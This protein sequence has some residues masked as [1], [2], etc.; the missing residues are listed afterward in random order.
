MT[1]LVAPVDTAVRALL[2]EDDADHAALVCRSLRQH[3]AAIE[4]DVVA[5]G[6]EALAALA[7]GTYALV[8][9]DYHLPEMTGLEVLR[10]VRASGRDV[11]VVILT[12]DGDDRAVTDAMQAGAIDYVI[13]TPGYFAGLGTVVSKALKQHALAREHAR[14]YAEAQSQARELGI[15]YELGTALT[16]T[17]SLADVLD[18]VAA[19]ALTL[20]DGARCIVFEVDAGENELAARA[21]RHGVVRPVSGMRLSALRVVPTIYAAETLERLL[22]GTTELLRV[23]AAREGARAVLAVPIVSKGTALGAIAVFWQQPRDDDPRELR[24][25]TALAQPAAVAIENARLYEE[26]QRTMAQLTAMQEHLVRGETLRALGELAGGVAHHLNNL[27]AVVSARTQ[28]LLMRPHDAA[29]ERPLE[30]IQ[31]AATDGAEVVRRIQEFARSRPN[32]KLEPLDFN[33]VVADVVELTRPRWHDAA[34]AQGIAIELRVETVNVPLIIGEGAALRE[35]VTNLIIN[36]VDALPVG[37]TITLR[38]SVETGTV[39]LTVIDDGVGMSEDVLR[40]AQEPFFTTKGVKSMG[41]GLSVNYGIVRQHQGT[42][43]IASGEGCGTTVTVRLPGITAGNTPE[44]P[45]APTPSS[46][47]RVWIVDDEPEVLDVV[48]EVLVE[49]GHDV[50]AFDDPRDAA[51]RLTHEAP[52]VLITDLGMPELRGWDLAR[53]A[54]E[55]WPALPVVVMTA[56]GSVEV[57]VEA[58][59][60]GAR[61]F[62]QKPWENTRLLTILRTQIELARALRRQQRLEAENRSLK[63][64]ARP[65]LIAEAPSMRPV[66]ELIARVGPSEANIL[67][68]GENGT[69]KGTVA[70]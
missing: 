4:V 1:R 28:L 9:L 48:R 26:M 65:L 29:I 3:D 46:P 34:R 45:A 35:V 16:S 70:Q 22:P 2:V 33:A 59:R 19:G 56:W 37:G 8:L 55:C 14:L 31:Q 12:A 61:D 7:A 25:L 51:T 11:A 43:D 18:A 13:K 24:L 50:I 64:D 41:L 30:I 6:R 63:P 47:R 49:A 36:A 66:L 69:G 42:I 10:R 15:L 17:H 21:T 5:N 39:V 57:A 67:V 68:T 32:Q 38:T 60:R 54:K 20:I 52:D 58:M 62:V 27:L 44:P 23:A 40:R 53:V